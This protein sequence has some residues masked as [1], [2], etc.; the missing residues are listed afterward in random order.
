[1]PPLAVWALVSSIAGFLLCGVILGPL[2][3]ALGFVAR[4]R[5]RA[6]GAP[7]DGIALAAIIVGVAAFVVNVAVIAV[8]LA[9]PDLMETTG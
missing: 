6:E 8:L 7:G 2:G 3:V 1:M 9:N 5:I 4:Q